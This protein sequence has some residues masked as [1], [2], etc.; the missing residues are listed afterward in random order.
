MSKPRE[1]DFNMDEHMEIIRVAVYDDKAY[2][3]HN[4]VFYEAETTREPDFDTARPIDVAALTSK[5]MRELFDILDEL[6]KKNE[7]E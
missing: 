7:L 3:V 6:G 1:D 5:D 4:N 2:W